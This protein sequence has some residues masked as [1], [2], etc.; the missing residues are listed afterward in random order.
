MTKQE[1]NWKISELREN[2][3][4]QMEHIEKCFM[5]TP[6]WHGEKQCWNQYEI[7]WHADANWPIL[8]CE[9]PAP[10]LDYFHS[11]RRGWQCTAELYN[12]DDPRRVF[13]DTPNEA[14][15]CAW[16]KWKGN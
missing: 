4:N 15:C 9:M 10:V 6:H 11:R 1:I 14:V 16:L 2:L 12:I 5:S 3:H 8:L 13:A 7:D